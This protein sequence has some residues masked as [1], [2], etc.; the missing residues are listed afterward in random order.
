[1]SFNL[2]AYNQFADG[3]FQHSY[4]DVIFLDLQIEL[5]SMAFEKFLQLID[6]ILA[7]IRVHHILWM[8]NQLQ[9]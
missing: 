1:M 3:I 9:V 6:F 2:D 7:S 8:Q 5:Q 4:T